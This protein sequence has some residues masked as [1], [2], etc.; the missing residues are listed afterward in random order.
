MS[1]QASAIAL[2][3]RARPSQVAASRPF[4]TAAAPGEN[5]LAT[6]FRRVLNEATGATA[7]KDPCAP[8]AAANPTTAKSA[9]A[10]Y[11]VQKGDTLSGVCRRALLAS[12]RDASGGAL[13]AAV[14]TVAQANG[15]ASANRIRVG[16]RLDLS[17]LGAGAAKAGVAPQTGQG[18][19]AAP[20]KPGVRELEDL[21]ALV[22]PGALSEAKASSAQSTPILDTAATISS[23]YGMR[24]NPFSKAMEHHDGVDLAVAAGSGIYPARDGTVVFSGW[25]AGY[26]KTVVVRHDN[27]LETLYGHNQSNLVRTGQRVT[28]ETRIAKVGSSGNSTGP[29]VHFEVR[30]DGKAINPSLM[31]E[32]KLLQ[33]AKAL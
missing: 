2:I 8:A 4:Q 20:W 24:R 33:V 22:R 1:E 21:L 13:A 31:V 10:P 15:L 16:Q 32:S 26:G 11:V 19:R 14:E 30:R 23:A 6:A 27:G 9:G 7:F 3:S 29:H 17:A 12:G 25:Q 5:R 28:S 18:G